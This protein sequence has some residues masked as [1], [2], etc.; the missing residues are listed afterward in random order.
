MNKG[1]TEIPAQMCEIEINKQ[2]NGQWHNHKN[3]KKCLLR[4]KIKERTQTK[5]ELKVEIL[6]KATKK[7][8]ESIVIILNKYKLTNLI[9]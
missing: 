3:K 9:I 8:K 5:S 1:K 6:Q 7:H 4:L 2:T